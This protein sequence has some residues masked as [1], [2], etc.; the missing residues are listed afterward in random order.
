MY[1]KDNWYKQNILPPERVTAKKAASMML[2]FRFL[3]ETESIPEAQKI[4]WERNQ[5]WLHKFLEDKKIFKQGSDEEYV[6]CLRMI[7]K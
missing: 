5:R 2:D 1:N 3:P 7:A 6:D 4:V